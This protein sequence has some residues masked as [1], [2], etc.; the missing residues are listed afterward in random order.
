MCVQSRIFARSV[1]IMTNLRWVCVLRWFIAMALLFYFLNDSNVRLNFN[2]AAESRHVC[3]ATSYD[4]NQLL[5]S[6]L[7]KFILVKRGKGI[8]LSNSLNRNENFHFS[9][10]FTSSFSAVLYSR[11]TCTSRL[12]LS[13]VVVVWMASLKLNHSLIGSR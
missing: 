5:E 12:A 8:G 2:L 4:H 1:A 10:L 11:H 6:L 13:A 9:R 7:Q 3:F